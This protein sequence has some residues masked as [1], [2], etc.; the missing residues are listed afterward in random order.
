M[1]IAAWKRFEK[2]PQWQRKKRFLKRLLGKELNLRKDVDVP[3][4]KHGG[5]WF[6]PD[7]LD[8]GSIVY[9]LGVGDEI[10]FDLALIEKYGVEVFAFD[11]TP[12]SVNMLDASRLPAKFH[13]HPWAVTAEDGTLA[14]YPRLKKDGTKSDVMFTMVPE[15]ETKNDVIEV[16]AFCLSTI[17]E[18][19]GHTHIDLLKMD[20]EGAEYEVLNGLLDSPVLPTQ[21]LVE[22]HHRFVANGLD[23]TYRLI[24]GLRGVG[25]GIFAISEIGREV[26]FLRQ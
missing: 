1:A 13:F 23:R 26:S 3:V 16:P 19:L 18:K 8:G 24:E 6:S 21:L 10:N 14:F 11:P 12:N 7:A 15:E 20:I 9:S 22:F 4:I 17:T 25:Y 5:W 2:T